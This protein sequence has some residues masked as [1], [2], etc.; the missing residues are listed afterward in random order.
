MSDLNLTLSTLIM[1]YS[2]SMNTLYNNIEMKHVLN[3]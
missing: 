1:Y 3:E 2:N